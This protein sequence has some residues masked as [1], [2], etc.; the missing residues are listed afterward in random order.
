M[1]SELTVESIGLTDLLS[2]FHIASLSIL[3]LLTLILFIV[4][5][6]RSDPKFQWLLS[7]LSI[8]IGLF[9]GVSFSFF[10]LKTWMYIHFAGSPKHEHWVFYQ[11]ESYSRLVAYLSLALLCLTLAIALRLINEKMPTRG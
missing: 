2:T 1:E 5:L 6:K 10:W 11:M 4:G 8:W 9:G 3:I 7:S